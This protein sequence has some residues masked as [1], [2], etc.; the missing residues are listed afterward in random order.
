[1]CVKESMY[2]YVKC[3][4]QIKCVQVCETRKNLYIYMFVW[5]RERHYVNM[6]KNSMFMC[7]DIMWIWKNSTSICVYICE[8][9]WEK[10]W[11]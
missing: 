11:V 5:E 9:M 1:M 6:K 7:V 4:Y 2:H 10:L 3:V 8:S